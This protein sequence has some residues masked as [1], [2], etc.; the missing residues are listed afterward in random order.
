VTMDESGVTSAAGLYLPT[1]T[2]DRSMGDRLDIPER[3]L[4]KL[5]EQGRLDMWAA[6]VNGRLHGNTHQGTWCVDHDHQADDRNHMLRLLRGDP[7]EAGVLRAF[8]SPSYKI[9]DSLDVLVAVLRGVQASGRDVKPT[10][11]DLSDRRF[12]MTL[13]CPSIATR[14]PKLLE[15]YRS[16]FEGT[17]ARERAGHE[18]AARLRAA[19][20][21]W[22]ASAQ[23]AAAAVGADVRDGVPEVGD[24]VWSGLVVSNSDTG[25][26]ARTISRQIRVLACKNGQT[27][28]KES[29]RKVHLGAVQGEGVVDW[30]VETLERE[31]QLITSQVSDAVTAWLTPEA[32][33]AE[34]NKIE[35]LAGV[36]ILAPEGTLRNVTKANGITK[37]E[38]DDILGFFVKG[39]Q[40]TA[41]GVMNA[42]TA[43]AQ[44]VSSAD[45]A[46]EL[47]A[48]AIPVLETAA[49]IGSR[50]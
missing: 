19:R 49:R 12:Y 39:G 14:A 27:I 48:K 15:G 32:L 46:F 9:M 26:G 34:V 5:R 29:D 22:A 23:V 37:A 33:A 43:Y 30:S 25:G 3:Y 36:P 24:I 38:T 45:R 44:T 40:M 6:N 47:E 17:G 50:A 42:V 31:L 41:G 16:P 4:T 35:A 21:D 8:L 1:E 11:C 2:G 13:E 20:G 10:V 18:N 7:G 28:T